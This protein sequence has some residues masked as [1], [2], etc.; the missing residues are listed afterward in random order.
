MKTRGPYSLAVAVNF[1]RRPEP[2]QL[3]AVKTEERAGLLYLRD[4]YTASPVSSPAVAASYG[5]ALSRL[6]I[7]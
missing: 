6:G 7:L 1:E 4:K 2:A 3:P 5:A